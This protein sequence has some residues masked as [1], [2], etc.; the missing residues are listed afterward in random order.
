VCYEALT[1]PT[2]GDAFIAKLQAKH[3]DTLQQLNDGL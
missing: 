1:L 3:A 2:D